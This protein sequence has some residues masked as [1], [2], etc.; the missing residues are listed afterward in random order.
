M[1]ILELNIQNV[2]SI[3]SLKLS[4]PLKPALYALTGKN[5][6]GKSTVM[7]SIA[8]LFFDNLLGVFFL[9]SA[10]DGSKISYSYN[11]N[12]LIY[13]FEN[14]NWAK[15]GSQNFL[16][17]FYEGSIIHGN[18]FRDTNYYALYSAQKVKKN[19]LIKAN[20]YIKENL[21]YILHDDKE[22]YKDLY[23]LPSDRAK[24]I[25][26][27]RGTPYFIIRNDK[28]ISQ[29]SLSTGENLL[30]SLLHSIDNQLFK[31][32]DKIDDYLILLD[33]VELA[34]HPAA[35]I[36]LLRFLKDLSKQRDVTIYFS[37]HSTDLIRSIDPSNIY[38][39]NKH[40]D[41]SVEV[42]NP[43]YPAYATRNIYMHD[44]YDYLILVEDILTKKMVDW[45][46]KK[47]NLKGSK[48][49]HIL[50]CGGWENVVSMH[51][52]IMT[53]NFL[54][55]GKKAFTILDGDVENEYKTKFLDNGLHKNLNVAFLPIQ[56]AEK[57]LRKKLCDDI[58]HKMFRHFND[59]F[60]HK[61]S[62]D[63]IMSEYKTQNFDTDKKG[64]VLLS[65]IKEEIEKQN[66]NFE[67]VTS[68]IVEYIVE[69]ENME[70]LISRF[71]K[72]F[73]NY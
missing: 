14:G 61:K 27:F 42:I 62:L 36:R 21:G 17:G 51:Q 11:N 58:D 45:L 25:F 7:A 66:S 16:H 59:S 35:L 41:D 12:E 43:C 70:K 64:K 50:P 2:R 39:L 20:N 72:T 29:L 4:L 56:S 1:N 60:F 6:T 18:R 15:S 54:G 47:A 69:N 68:L 65:I 55:I 24:Q 9:N 30:I 33:E 38:F 3:K 10:Q 53:S 73:S 71:S 67:D 49:I 63:D 40:I 26:K 28:L 23:K 31:R 32:K 19:E 37:T 52:E 13:T 8:N 22:F 5:A 57:F 46:L 44:G 34:L 48:L